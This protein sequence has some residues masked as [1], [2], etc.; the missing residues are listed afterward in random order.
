MNIFKT[1]LL[2]L[3]NCFDIFNS[4]Q[5]ANYVIPL[6]YYGS[7]VIWMRGNVGWSSSS[8][9]TYRS[10]ARTPSFCAHWGRSSKY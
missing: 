6:W 8:M 9:I 5:A 1:I 10:K 7:Y 3:T 2:C 4:R